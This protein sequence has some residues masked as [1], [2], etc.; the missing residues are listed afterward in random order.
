MS[1][2]LPVIGTPSWGTPL[3]SALS[4]LAH[5]GFDA[6]DHGLI[7]WNYDVVQISSSAVPTSGQLRLIRLPDLTQSRTVTSVA[8]HI[9]TAPVGGTA[10]QNF[11]GLYSS[12]GTRLAQSADCTV[13]FSTAGAK[14]IAL[15]A[16]YAAVPGRY[17]VG[18]LANAATP[19]AFGHCS[20]IATS[21]ANFNLAT[22]LS[23]FANGPSAQTTLPAT[24]TMASVTPSLNAT[25]AGIA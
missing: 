13:D 2:T 17:Y 9:N 19:A 11:V 23:R 6:N 21:V 10:G 4:T 25:W 14:L 3:N 18:I 1:V 7:M 22:A 5:D 24:V 20:S 15:T 12:T 16:P 8:M